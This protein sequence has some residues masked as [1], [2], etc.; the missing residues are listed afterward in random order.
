M[1]VGDGRKKG[2]DDGATFRLFAGRGGA[3]TACGAAN[4]AAAPCEF[5]RKLAA[6]PQGSTGAWAGEGA[7]IRLLFLGSGGLGLRAKGGL[8]DGR[9]GLRWALP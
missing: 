7:W 8:G 1:M 5:A 2:E 4:F 3:L 6:R 9:A